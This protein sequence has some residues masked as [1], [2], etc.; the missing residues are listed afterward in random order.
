MT[1]VCLDILFLQLVIVIMTLSSCCVTQ[2][3]ALPSCGGPL[4]V[5]VNRFVQIES[6]GRGQLKIETR[7]KSVE[8]LITDTGFQPPS[9]PTPFPTGSPVTDKTKSSLFK[10]WSNKS[11]LLY[12]Q[13]FAWKTCVTSQPSSMSRL[14]GRRL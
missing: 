13:H 1:F 7:L 2:P 8:V 3:G 12:F 6:R 5:Q 10:I 9:Q 4:P 11:F 14:V